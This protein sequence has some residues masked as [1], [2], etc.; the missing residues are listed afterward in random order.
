MKLIPLTQG[1]FAK[2]DDDMYDSLI[3]H[4]WMAQYSPITKTYYATRNGSRKNGIRNKIIRM[5]RM[6]I[7]VEDGKIVDHR[8]HDTLNNQVTNLRPCS[9]SEN[10]AN[11]RVLAGKSGYRG[12]YPKGSRWSSKIVVNGVFIY[13]GQFKCK[14]E[15]AKEWNIISLWHHGEFAYQNII[16]ED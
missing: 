2:V 13:L 1:Q 6:I 16:K 9:Y 4:K 5:H 3:K 7:N 8:D 14:H 12:V 10:M 15:A 11:S